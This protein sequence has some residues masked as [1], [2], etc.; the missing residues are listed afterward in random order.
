MHRGERFY[1]KFYLI[2]EEGTD[3][4]AVTADDQGDAHYRYKNARGFNQ[5]GQLDSNSRKDVI[6]W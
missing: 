5:Y 6:M 4:L 1:L 3:V 2:D